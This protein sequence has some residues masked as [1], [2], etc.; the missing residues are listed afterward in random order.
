MRHSH[1]TFIHLVLVASI[2]L[3]AAILGGCTRDEQNTDNDTTYPDAS[4]DADGDGDTDADTDTDGDADADSD[5]DAD[6]DA[7]ADADTDADADSDADADTDSDTD[8]DADSDTDSDADSDTDSAV[9]ETPPYTGDYYYDPDA[10]QGMI[11]SGPIQRV[12][13]W[14][15]IGDVLEPFRQER[16][17][18]DPSALT[19]LLSNPYRDDDGT[20]LN[21]GYGI[22][23]DFTGHIP[24]YTEG[25]YWPFIGP[26][27]PQPPHND[28][29][30][31]S[32]IYFIDGVRVK[33][34]EPL[35]LPGE[36]GA[37]VHNAT[38]YSI[39]LSSGSYPGNEQPGQVITVVN[40]GQTVDL[41]IPPKGWYPDGSGNPRVPELYVSVA[42]LDPMDVPGWHESYTTPDYGTPGFAF[43]FGS[44]YTPM[45]GADED[46]LFVGF[47]TNEGYDPRLSQDPGYGVALYFQANGGTKE[48]YAVTDLYV[49]SPNTAAQDLWALPRFNPG[50][51]AQGGLSA[52]PNAA[53]GSGQFIYELI[54][55]Q[56][57]Q[58][59]LADLPDVI[60]Q[61]YST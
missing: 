35:L 59:L 33:T 5:A 8:S 6:T 28:M 51:N 25:N 38:E 18:V 2:A 36:K 44:K 45:P 12:P 30:A 19:G 9:E 50:I 39:L 47:N 17:Y 7:D 22:P 57:A 23:P 10:G 11:R 29:H 34:V 27:Q 49:T 31:D 21:A 43:T 37:I 26:Y 61:T 16:G 13:G 4:G 54:T 24:V 42:G 58:L 14:I 60:H 20:G 48:L 55:H 53:E 52:F 15:Y 40:P 41:P 3:G 56:Q 32:G 1:H 46:F